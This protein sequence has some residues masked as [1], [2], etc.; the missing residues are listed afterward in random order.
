V[1]ILSKFQDY[2]DSMA[3]YGID[4]TLVYDRKT[5]TKVLD[6]KVFETWQ[7]D[8]P[9]TEQIPSLLKYSH[10]KIDFYRNFLFCGGSFYSYF[11]ATNGKTIYSLSKEPIINEL[12]LDEVALRAF[13]EHHLGDS[14]FADKKSYPWRTNYDDLAQLFTTIPQS[15][16]KLSDRQPLWRL[17]TRYADLVMEYNPNLKALGLSKFIS[18]AKVHQNISMWL[19]SHKD[20]PPIPSIDDKTMRDIKG[21][22]RYSFRKAK[23]D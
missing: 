7:K 5:S 19:G 13:G 21:F 8:I 20:V 18:P 16:K 23:V 4:T 22:D 17:Y 9:F 14:F 6:R 2:Y 15:V 10:G 1:R 3:M 12:I 11:H